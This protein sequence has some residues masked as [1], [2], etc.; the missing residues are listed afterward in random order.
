[1]FEVFLTAEQK[2]LLKE[3]RDF[4]KWVPRQLILD[5]D[6]EKIKFPKEF[7]EE[8]GR[9][10]LLALRAPKQYGGRGL[11]YVDDFIVLGEVGKLGVPLACV[12]G[13]V[14]LISDAL[15]AFGTKSQKQ[16]Y[17]K[18][19]TAGKIW[20]GEALTEPRGGSDFFGATTTARKEGK[21]YILNGHASW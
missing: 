13:I 7:I 8:A 1:V 3:V 11:K 15:N 4:V 12:F 10:N 20:A 18:P 2:G 6:D 21:H 19:L 16:K 17:L 14:G 9:R 5:M